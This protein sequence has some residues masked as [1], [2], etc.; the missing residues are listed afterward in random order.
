MVCQVKTC[1]SLGGVEL[2]GCEQESSAFCASFRALSPVILFTNDMFY[3]SFPVAFPQTAV[4]YLSF[5]VWVQIG[6]SATALCDLDAI[7]LQQPPNKLVQRPAFGPCGINRLPQFLLLGVENGFLRGLALLCEQGIFFFQLCLPIALDVVLPVCDS[8]CRP[9]EQVNLVE[10]PTLTQL[11]NLFPE[12]AHKLS[13]AA[14][15]C[16]CP[17]VTGALHVVPPGYIRHPHGMDDYV[18]VEIPGFLVPVCVRTDKGDMTGEVL[19]TELLSHALN[20][21]QRQTVIL[22]VPW[23]KGENVVVGLYVPRLLVLT[24]FQICLDA[25]QGKAVRGTEDTGDEIFRPGDIVS[26]LVQKGTLGLL[27]VLKAEVEGSGGVVGV[28]TG[29]VLDD[30]HS[31]C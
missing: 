6:E 28:F 16:A 2:L 18:T 27:V 15:F 3:A 23:V 30:C 14:V 9:G 13:G 20:F 7:V 22:S 25:R 1:G 8:F 31:S 17:A 19:L 5:C 4:G 10:P 12:I 11:H 26:L 24:V 21:F 29:N